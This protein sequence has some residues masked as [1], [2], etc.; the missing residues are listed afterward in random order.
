MYIL[1]HR[2]FSVC[3]SGLQSHNIHNV[4]DT[5]IITDTT[6]RVLMVS[7]YVIMEMWN[8]KDSFYGLELL[9]P[10]C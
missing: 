5:D 4:L 10:L 8:F 9:M 6:S 3:M 2:F 1:V 7:I